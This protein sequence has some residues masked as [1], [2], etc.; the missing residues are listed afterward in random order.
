MPNTSD[1]PDDV[2]IVALEP[3]ADDSVRS[4]IAR[5]KADDVLSVHVVAPASHIGTLQWLTG[6]E[7]EA[8]AEAEELADQTAHAV[9]AE[10]ET[11]VGD[12]DLLLAVMDALVDFP[13]D[14]ILVA[15]SADEKAEAELRR[16][17]LRISRLDGEEEIAAEP[18]TGTEGVARDVT[19]GQR[20]ETPFVILGL[21]GGLLF[22]A[23]VLISMIAFLVAWLA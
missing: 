10:V 8:H 11:E 21:V 3:V 14:E 7:D 20:P 17:G 15:G 13:A 9:D 18:P 5:R 6:A 19:H 22:G 16:F 2:L 4:A 23:I 1:Q 12:R